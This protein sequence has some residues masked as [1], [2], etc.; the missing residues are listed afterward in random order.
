MIKK[1]YLHR[2]SGPPGTSVKLSRSRS[3][4]PEKSTRPPVWEHETEPPVNSEPIPKPEDHPPYDRRRYQNPDYEK[5]YYPENN[6]RSR[7]PSPHKIPVWEV[8]TRSVRPAP[9]YTDLSRNR[10]DDEQTEHRQDRSD[11]RHEYKPE[12]RPERPEH[13][14][15]YKPDHRQEYKPDHR[16]EYKQDHRQES[17]YENPRSYQRYDNRHEPQSE[18]RWDTRRRPYSQRGGYREYNRP[19]PSGDNPNTWAR[20]SRDYKNDKNKVKLVDY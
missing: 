5:S 1:Y 6:L 20:E 9:S 3:N 16:Q 12:Y 4:S 10:F 8:D 19:G 11:H 18:D 2:D 14:Q 7:S 13:R 17:R 15:E